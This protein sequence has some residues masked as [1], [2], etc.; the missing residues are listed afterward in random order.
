VSREYHL[1][2]RDRP[3]AWAFARTLTEA[4]GHKV[5]IDGDFEDPD[6]YLNISSHDLWVEVEPPG[7]IEAVDLEEIHEGVKLPEPDDEGCLWHTVATIPAS[8]PRLGADAI[9]Q[10]FRRL[11]DANHG[12]AIDP[13]IEP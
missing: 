4:V 12:I 5:D 13:Q 9:W 1:V 6:D 8:A 10:T 11:T 2:T 3:S 7:H